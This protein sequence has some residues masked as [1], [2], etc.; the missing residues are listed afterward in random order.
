[1]SAISV[2]WWVWWL[3]WLACNCNNEPL[4]M[5]ATDCHWP[6]P[7]PPRPHFHRFCSLVTTGLVRTLERLII[8]AE[9]YSATCLLRELGCK[10]FSYFKT[11][12]KS[13]VWPGPS[14]G[15]REN[16]LLKISTVILVSTFS[17]HFHKEKGRCLSVFLKSLLT[18]RPW[19]SLGA[20]M[21]GG[22]EI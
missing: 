2:Q 7:G 18:L 22:D 15:G 1:M 4:S 11:S 20:L 13:S 9:Y 17:G 10:T 5:T 19:Q 12:S 6:S 21:E 16:S 3:W 14:Y 8:T